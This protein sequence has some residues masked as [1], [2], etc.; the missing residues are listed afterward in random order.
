MAP[1]KPLFSIR[2]LKCDTMILTN[3][4]DRKFSRHILHK[5]EG[6]ELNIYIFEEQM[7][8]YFMITSCIRAH[9]IIKAYIIG[10][11]DTHERCILRFELSGCLDC[12][13]FSY[14]HHEFPFWRYARKCLPYKLFSHFMFCGQ[15]IWV[16]HFIFIQLVMPW[17]VYIMT[18]I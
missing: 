7:W 1:D 2:S 12:S 8:K 17:Y 6:L 16:R 3:I 10:L 11:Q 15:L 4:L 13:L 18:I 9:H 14:W 5:K